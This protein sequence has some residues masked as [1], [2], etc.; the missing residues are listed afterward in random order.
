MSL[1]TSCGGGIF[2]LRPVL[3]GRHLPR[4]STEHPSH[5]GTRFAVLA[6]VEAIAEAI[7]ARSPIWRPSHIRPG[8]LMSYNDCMQN[9]VSI[10]SIAVV[11]VAMR[12][13]AKATS[14]EGMIND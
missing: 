12:S 13:R 4:K 9:V 2:K 8:S 6:A 7:K 1:I 3:S 10:M 11:S 14:R 5:Q